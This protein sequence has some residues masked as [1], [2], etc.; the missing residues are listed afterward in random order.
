[1]KQRFTLFID[2]SGD[3]GISKVRSATIASGASPYMT[4]GAAFI[5]NDL[6]DSI[7]ATLDRLGIDFGGKALHCSSLG[8]YEK[9]HFIREMVQHKVR[10]FGLISYKDTLGT[11]KS[12]IEENSKK[13][14]NKCA[15]YLLERVGWFM[16]ATG[17]PA[18]NL[19]IV[20]E[21]GNF[22]YEKLYVLLRK[23]QQKPLQAMTARLNNIKVSNIT[24]KTK[25]EEPLL[26]MADL[27]AHALYKC[28]DKQDKNHFISE[29]RYL[30]ELGPRFF[31]HPTTRKVAGSGLYL[32]HKMS[33]LDLDPD[34][35]E[36]I[37]KMISD[38]PG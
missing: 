32:V 3:A 1:M 34:V 29:P 35:E 11:Y 16:E 26:Q 12:E 30:R 7:T 20:F 31:G 22:D 37:Q 8:H 24:T 18:D 4:M 38:L 28:V 14:Y 27:V 23:C 10:L 21:R 15:Q 17:I 36:V 2:E 25:G 9:L 5:S 13:F 19:D 33:D 6:R